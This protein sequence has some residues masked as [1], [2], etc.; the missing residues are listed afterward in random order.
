MFVTTMSLKIVNATLPD[1]AGFWNIE[2]ANGYITEIAVADSTIK[3]TDRTLDA[4]GKLLIPGLVDAHIHLDKALLLDRDPA[5]EGT[6]AEALQKTLQAKQEYTLADIQTR[7]RT[8]IEKAIAF[9]TTAMRTHV[10]VDPILQLKSLEALLPLKEKYAWGITLQLAVFAQEGITNQP[11]TASL[12]RK[13]MSMGGDV[14]G[15][16]P[17][18][19]PNPEENIRLIFEIAQEFNCDIDFH[20]DFLD[21]DA[22]LLLPVVIEETLK[23]NWQNRVCLGHMTKLAGLTPK[24][25]AALIPSLKEAG[26]AILALP[27]T[28]LYMMARQDTHNVRR[29]VAPVH[30]LAESGIKVGIA[31]N[32]VQNLFTPFGDGDVL[33]ICTLLA[34]VLQLG[35][36]ASHQLCLE[37]ATSRAAQAI[38]INNYGIEVGKVADLVLLEA[39]SVSSAI[40]TAP[41]NRTTIKRGQIVAQSHCA[42]GL[43]ENVRF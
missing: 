34:Q 15:S 24:E 43:K 23:H 17:Y 37:M 18:V 42:V 40:G 26:I 27:A 31:T 19:D 10:E 13:A 9:G 29:G 14:I 39:N 4:Q 3:E 5:I 35:T 25:L 20:L 2:I 21:D 16:A 38:G 12:L 41:L 7:A 28:D 22:P 1:R 33:K 11:G 6:F 8:I 30:Q 36:T 32:N